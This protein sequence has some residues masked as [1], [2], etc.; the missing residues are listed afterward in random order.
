VI[1][2]SKK[3]RICTSKGA[4]LFPET[5]RRMEADKSFEFRQVGRISSGSDTP[6]TSPLH[7]STPMETTAPATAETTPT[8]K[9]PAQE[10][11]AK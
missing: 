11:R 2:I 1:Y 4:T 5:R 6:K 9:R 10:E 3:I 7:T 8:R